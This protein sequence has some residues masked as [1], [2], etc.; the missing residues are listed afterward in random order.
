MLSASSSY[1][2]FYTKYDIP[3]CYPPLPS[4]LTHFWCYVLPCTTHWALSRRNND[5][6]SFDFGLKVSEW[7]GF[8]GGVWYTVRCKS[9]KTISRTKKRRNSKHAN[10][11]SSLQTGEQWKSVEFSNDFPNNFRNNFPGFTRERGRIF[12]RSYGNFPKDP[13]EVSIGSPTILCSG[14]RTLLANVIAHFEE[15]MRS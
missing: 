4:T 7:G 5:E 10:L 12:L 8:A 15:M 6:I 14:R 9:Q 1:R 11:C 2:E 13:M 3:P